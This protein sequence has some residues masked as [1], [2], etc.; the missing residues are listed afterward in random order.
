MA[1]SSS[2]SIFT[3]P[4]TNQNGSL[5]LD[6]NNYLMWL[7][8]VLVILRTHDLMGIVDG[9]E[10][11]PEKFITDDKGK[12]NLNP[13]FADW[14]KKDQYILSIITNSLIEKVLATVYGLNSSKQAWIALATKFASQSKSRI[15]HLKQQ[16]QSLSQGPQSCSD[17]LQTAK[18]F[19]DQLT[20]VSKPIDDEDFIA[21][22]INGLNPSFTS[23]ITTYSFATR[24][25][26]LTF[27]DFEDQLLS[28][29]M[30]LNQ[31][32]R[33][34]TDNSSF[35]LSASTPT[36]PQPFRGKAPPFS[37]FPPRNFNNRPNSGFPS[38]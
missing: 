26:T 1:S 17:Y 5:K 12:E 7:T 33:K 14:N 4:N 10:P 32:Q 20:A 35:V 23:F 37:K 13:E 36:Y 34:V 16:L 38:P 19:A 6:N 15:T 30:L 18:G 22:V 25:S 21:L 8:Q 29:E 28:H 9:S 3:P 2:S 24:E 27:E 31:K 11:C